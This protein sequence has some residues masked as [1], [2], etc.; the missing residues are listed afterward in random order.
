[1]H[2]ISDEKAMVAF[3]EALAPSL[4]P[5][6][7]V[8]LKGPLGAGKTTFVKG[9]LHAL[10]GTEPSSV[11]SPTYSYVHPYQGTVP[12]FHFDLYRLENEETFFGLDLDAYFSVEGIALIE[13][14][15]R[16]P[17]LISSERGRKIEI[18]ISY[19]ECGRAVE[20]KGL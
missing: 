2:N 15:E 9:I 8:L 10:M 1:L 16:V 11:Q 19:T 20:V 13:W 3:A 7:L 14:P 18:E 6:D 17:S 12:I 4:H 5:G